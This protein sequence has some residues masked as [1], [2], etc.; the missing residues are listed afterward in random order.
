MEGPGTEAGNEWLEPVDNKT[1]SILQ[2]S[3]YRYSGSNS[4]AEALKEKLE[5]GP[6]TIRMED[7]GRMEKV[8]T[9]DF[10]L[11]TNDEQ[12]TT[13]PGDVILY[14]GNQITVYYDTNS[15]TIPIPGG[16][17]GWEGLTT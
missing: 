9:L 16:S 12:I 11:P 1:Y 3:F 7:Y 8:G 17:P 6:V 13:E 5:Q 2:Y 10:H 14:Q 15:C 4:S